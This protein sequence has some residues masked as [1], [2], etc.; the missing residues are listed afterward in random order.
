MAAASPSFATPVARSLGAPFAGVW[1]E[2]GKLARENAARNPRRTSSTAAA[3]MIGLALVTMALIVGN[4]VKTTF[5]DALGSSV[6]ADWYIDTG[7]FFPFSPE[8]AASLNSLDEIGEVSQLRFGNMA[9]DD[10][11]RSFNALDYGTLDDMFDIGLVDGSVSG[12]EPGLLINEEPAEE[13]GLEVGDTVEVTFNQTGTVELPV[14][15]I[16]EKSAVLGNWILDLETYNDN[17]TE[18][19]DFAG[20]R[21]DRAT[22]PRGCAERHRAHDR[23]LPRAA[24]A[25]RRGVPGRQRGAARPAPLHHQPLPRHDHRH[26]LH[27]HRE[28]ARPLGLR[29]HARARPPPGGGA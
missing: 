13:L 14:R 10:E 9:I 26:R 6:R 8:V 4:S 1:R 3:L 29:A 15:G 20:D 28:H 18:Q 12:D 11:A 7:S 5:I 21:D 27:R 16:Y 22:R 19:L 25:G 2:P 17:F 24:G 23:A